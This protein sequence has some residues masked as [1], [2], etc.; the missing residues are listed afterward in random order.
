VDHVFNTRNIFALR[1]WRLALLLAVLTGGCITQSVSA[2][3]PD[4]WVYPPPLETKPAENQPSTDYRPPN[5]PSPLYEQ[6]LSSP[7]V[8]APVP[9][10]PTSVSPVPQ[11]TAVTPPIVP[12][13]PQ[14]APVRPS[15]NMNQAKQSAAAQPANTT[16]APTPVGET[17]PEQMTATPSTAVLD[18][19]TR[20]T[21]DSTAELTPSSKRSLTG[22]IPVLLSIVAV[23]IAGGLGFWRVFQ[24]RKNR[25]SMS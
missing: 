5:T 10:P 20:K 22:S 4:N 21:V 16:T 24:K 23:M 14:S 25:P 13:K 17:G 12:M 9:V 18:A 2:Q 6:G 1:H 15:A 3:S 7:G 11:P 19:A 8:S